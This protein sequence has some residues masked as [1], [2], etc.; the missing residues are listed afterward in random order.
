[1]RVITALNFKRELEVHYCTLTD[2][3][4]QRFRH[5]TFGWW[6]GEA[7]HFQ[8]YTLRVLSRQDRE[9]FCDGWMMLIAES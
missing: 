8:V 5:S 2:L 4:E 1:M 3:R 7:V 6:Q 9:L